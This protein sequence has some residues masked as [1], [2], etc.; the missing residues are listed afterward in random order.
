ML[1]DS[2][3][4]KEELIDWYVINSLNRSYNNGIEIKALLGWCCFEKSGMF[5]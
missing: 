1:V 5:S 2:C 3:M 4:L